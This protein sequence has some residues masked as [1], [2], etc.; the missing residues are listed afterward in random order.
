MGDR[1]TA[2][3][4]EAPSTYLQGK[5]HTIAAYPDIMLLIALNN[6]VFVYCLLLDLLRFSIICN[7]FFFQSE[8]SLDG[9]I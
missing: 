8:M 9:F 3:T 2:H 6:S 1:N 7:F 5:H 4:Q